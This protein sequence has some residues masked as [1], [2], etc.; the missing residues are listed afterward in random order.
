MN[1]HNKSLKFLKPPKPKESN[2]EIPSN[3]KLETRSPGCKQVAEQA[4]CNEPPLESSMELDKPK[5]NNN[6]MT[7]STDVIEVGLISLNPR[8]STESPNCSLLKEKQPTPE[9]K[10][11]NLQTRSNEPSRDDQKVETPNK[12]PSSHVTTADESKPKKRKK[13]KPKRK[14]TQAESLKEQSA[15]ETQMDESTWMGGLENIELCSDDPIQMRPMSMKKLLR[16]L[17]R[18]AAADGAREEARGDDDD[19]R[20]RTSLEPEGRCSGTA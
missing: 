17:R 10:D 18:V 3:T 19:P 7:R 20:T 12:E 16:N 13:K 2:K 6:R 15:R 1:G 5:E 11:A 9:T 8:E 4:R 14:A